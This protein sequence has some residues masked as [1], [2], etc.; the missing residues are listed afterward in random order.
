MFGK[1]E[2]IWWEALPRGLQTGQARKDLGEL[3][4]PGRLH[5]H[6]GG[7]Q[8]NGLAGLVVPSMSRED[9]DRNV[10]IATPDPGEN[11]QAAQPGHDEV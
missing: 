9:H 1:N 6:L 11:G 4:K 2:A 10:R 7:S 8:G 3:G 5:D